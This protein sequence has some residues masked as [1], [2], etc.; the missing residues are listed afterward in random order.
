MLLRQNLRRSRSW[1]ASKLF[2]SVE[3]DYDHGNLRGP[4]NAILPPRNK[5]LLR[6]YF[7][8]GGWHWGGTR[9]F[10]WYQVFFHKLEKS[11]KVGFSPRFPHVDSYICLFWWWTPA[12]EPCSLFPYKAFEL[13]WIV[14]IE[15]GTIFHHS[16]VSFLKEPFGDSITPFKQQ[17]K[18]PSKF[19]GRISYP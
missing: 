18:T 11:W 6:P 4:P 15:F 12:G 5:G 7:L 13:K 3:S 17:V 2:F 10:P 19:S 14:W 1:V 16:Q 9:R 8:G